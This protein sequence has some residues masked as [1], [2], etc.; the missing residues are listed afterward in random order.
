MLVPK[1]LLLRCNSQKYLPL[2]NILVPLTPAV[3][4]LQLG[5]KWAI[6]K[7]GPWSLTSGLLSRLSHVQISS[8]PFLSGL[9]SESISSVAE[10]SADGPPDASCGC[11]AE[12]GGEQSGNGSSSLKNKVVLIFPV[13]YYTK[14]GKEI[15]KGMG[16]M[17]SYGEKTINN[18]GERMIY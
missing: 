17:E 3:P 14:I 2:F 5:W 6:R 11:Y 10:E 18:N 4:L 16:C 12:E 8:Q 9:A 15:H 1:I 7:L 13:H